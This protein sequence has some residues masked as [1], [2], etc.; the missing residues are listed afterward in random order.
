MGVIDNDFMSAVRSN[1]H[2]LTDAPDLGGQK[3]KFIVKADGINFHGGT[4]VY[5]A[6]GLHRCAVADGITT[7]VARG[8][9]SMVEDIVYELDVAKT[10]AAN[11]MMI[12]NPRVRAL[13]VVPNTG[14]VVRRVISSARDGPDPVKFKGTREIKTQV[15]TTLLQSQALEKEGRGGTHLEIPNQNP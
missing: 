5:E 4:R 14:D 8:H 2:I 12:V 6:E 15:E 3:G 7:K 1:D 11:R 10:K 13:E 9:L